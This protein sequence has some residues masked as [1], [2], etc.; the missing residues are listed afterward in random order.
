MTEFNIVLFDDFETLDAFGPAEIIGKMAETYSLKYFSC[1]GGIVTSSQNIKTQTYPFH[2]LNADGVLLIPGGMGTRKL[3][4]DSGFIHKLTIAANAAAFVLTVCTGSA[5]L[6]KTN[7][8]DNRQATSNKKAFD[9]VQSVNE[10]V[11]WVKHARWV[12]DGRF[13]TSSGISAGMDMTLGFISDL[14]GKSIAQN[15]A[16]AIEYIWNSDKNSD[17]FSS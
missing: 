14:H 8:L 2:E 5:L 1:N 16:D 15:V 9:W 6:A 12:V 17:P 4:D 10:A 7:L 13:Y 3:V 11:I